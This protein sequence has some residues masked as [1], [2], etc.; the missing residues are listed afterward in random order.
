LIQKIKKKD[1]LILH[2]FKI[3]ASGQKFVNPN[4]KRFNPTNIVKNNQYLEC[5]NPSKADE[6][7][8]APAIILI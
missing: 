2:F 1:Y 5:K 6:N 3:I 4:W 8:N 7:T